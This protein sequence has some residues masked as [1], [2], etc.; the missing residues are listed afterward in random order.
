MTKEIELKVRLS[1]ANLPAL[2]DFLNQV[3]TPA[4]HSTLK[5]DYYDT[6]ACALS[7]AKAAL[8]IRHTEGGAE[9][10]LK[11]RGQSQAGLQ[12]RGEWNWPLSSPALDVSL[13]EQAEVLD[14]WPAGVDAK[15]LAVVFG[16]HFERQ[17]W[18]WTDA[19]S[20]TTIEVVIDQG[21]IVAGELEQPLLEVELELKQG[22]A[23]L[24]WTLVAQMQSVAPL[25]ISDI[26]KAERGYRLADLAPQW[27]AKLP[28]F[29]DQR[30]AEALPLW[31][32]AEMNALQRTLEQA[33]WAEERETAVAAI[34]HVQGLRQVLSWS[35]RTL[36]RSATKELRTALETLRL[37]IWELAKNAAQLEDSSWS[38]ECAKW[39]QNSTLASAL[40]NASRALYELPWPEVEEAS[41][42]VGRALLRHWLP[43]DLARR[44]EQAS[45]I[46]NWPDLHEAIVQMLVITRYAQA[47][48]RK[49]GWIKTAVATRLVL[50]G[51]LECYLFDEEPNADDLNLMASEFRHL[52]TA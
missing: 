50:T 20:D 39:Q 43:D 1:E 37:A 51:M 25:W 24:L 18:L 29:C 40:L 14:A 10:T 34:Q 30:M 22:N 46:N 32:N 36:K 4:D 47:A 49:S 3:A 41:S 38:A 2:T 8:R 19:S 15:T 11:T 48:D 28:V 52:I 9:Q 44:F 17:A 31:L 7:K 33:I 13:F 27:Q 35:G 26:S 42:H 16:T 12:I 5:N 45:A 6:P 23:N 21:L